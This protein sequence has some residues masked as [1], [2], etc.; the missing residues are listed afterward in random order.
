[1]LLACGRL[2]F[3]GR[4]SDAAAAKSSDAPAPTD[5]ERRRT[6]YGSTA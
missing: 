2:G 3:D 4:T 5:A 6:I 1:M